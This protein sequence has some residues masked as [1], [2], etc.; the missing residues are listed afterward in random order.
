MMC[1]KLSGAPI[2]LSAQRYGPCVHAFKRVWVER[3]SG[4]HGARANMAVLLSA[5]FAVSENFGQ[6]DGA[7]RYARCQN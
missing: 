4:R 1:K 2:T 6:L 5:V 7:G 3:R